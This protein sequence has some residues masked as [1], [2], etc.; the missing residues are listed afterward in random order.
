MK[1]PTKKQRHEI[2][3]KAFIKFEQGGYLFMCNVIHS[4]YGKCDKETFP[5]L[6]LFEPENQGGAG[7]FV[8]ESNLDLSERMEVKETI[9]AFCMAMSE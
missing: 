1:K 3:K 2:Y 7:W 8:Y 6:F 9:L 4:M 5:E